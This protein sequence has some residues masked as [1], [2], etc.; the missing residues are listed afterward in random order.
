M[1][2]F[3]SVIANFLYQQ[4]GE[5]CVIKFGVILLMKKENLNKLVL[6]CFLSDSTWWFIL[7]LLGH[8]YIGFIFLSNKIMATYFRWSVLLIE[9]LQL[10][11]VLLWAFIRCKLTGRPFADLEAAERDVFAR[12]PPVSFL[13]FMR[14]PVPC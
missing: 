10:V 1:I 13:L 2:S 14:A 9:K 5:H 11:A 6:L 12:F 3:F 8:D 4:G 7:T